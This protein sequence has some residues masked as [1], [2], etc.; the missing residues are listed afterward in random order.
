MQKTMNTDESIL[1]TLLN[2]TF[3]ISTV[4][5]IENNYLKN[6]KHVNK[7]KCFSDYCFDDKNK[8]ND[9][10]TF[11]M[12]PHLT[13]ENLLKYF[14]DEFVKSDIKNTRSINPNYITFLKNY[15][16][17]NF[18]FIINDR[19]NL[20]GN[21]HEERKYYLTNNYLAIKNMYELWLANQPEKSMYYRGIIKKLNKCLLN[22]QNNKKINQLIDVILIAFL[23]AYVSSI[24]AKR[25]NHLEI[26]GWFSDRDKIH[27]V[28]KGLVGDLFHSNLHN[29][30]SA[31][32]FTFAVAPANSNFKIFYDHLI[33]VPDY[34]AGTISDY[35][36]IENKISKD[37]FDTML[38]EYMA[39]NEYNNYV[40]KMFIEDNEYSCSKLKIT[41]KI[42]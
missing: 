17:I 39:D 8:P 41:K 3:D 6:L 5:Q 31:K 38:T 33:K 10:V 7:W 4:E 32:H 42:D 25:I 11:T 1:S 36:I 16:L 20:F 24:I 9:V 37:K 28:E 19:K 35:N 30:L 29:L 22:I 21:S 23:G 2:N 40:F 13:D 27:D 15:P 18:S 12:F 26:F 14:F 34:I